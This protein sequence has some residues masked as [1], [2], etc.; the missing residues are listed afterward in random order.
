MWWSSVHKFSVFVEIWSVSVCVCAHARQSGLCAALA[1]MRRCAKPLIEK[2]ATEA[3]FPTALVHSCLH[4]Q[5]LRCAPRRSVQLPS[6][7]APFYCYHFVAISFSVTLSVF[8]FCPEL[9]VLE[10]EA[11]FCPP[12]PVSCAPPHSVGFVFH[13]RSWTGSCLEVKSW[14][15]ARRLMFSSRNV[16]SYHTHISRHTHTPRT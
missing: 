14:H 5:G 15:A 2:H 16:S 6:S 8:F 7:F 10:R 1:G 3:A 12:P 13:H 4:Q 9:A 11:P